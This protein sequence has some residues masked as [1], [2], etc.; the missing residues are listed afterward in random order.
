MMTNGRID[1]GSLAAAITGDV[2]VP[3]DDGYDTTR[4]VWNGMVDRRPAVI[5]RCASTHDVVAAIAFGREHGLEL[6]TRGG[7]HNVA[8]R[9]VVD[10][11]LMIDLGPMT[12]VRVDPDARRAH[13]QPGARWGDV[14]QATQAHGLATPGG[15]VSV[16]GV[17]G[18]TLG[19]GVGFLSCAYGTASDNLVAAE[20]VTADGEVVRANEDENPDLLWALRGG[21]GGFGVVTSFEFALHPVGPE[22]AVAQAYVLAD[23]ARE[24]LTFLREYSADS[25][26]EVGTYGLAI[27]IPPVDPFPAEHHGKVAIAI[28]AMHPGSVEEGERVLA[29]IGEFDQAILA[30]VAPMPYVDLQQ[31]FDAGSPDGSRYYFKSQYLAAL[32]DEA[33]DVIVDHLDPFP[34]DFTMIGLEPM[35][36]AISRVPRDATAFPHR[37]SQFVFGVWAG[38]SDPSEDDQMMAWARSVHE[39]M[40]PLGNGGMYAN[41]LDQ[42]DADV[43]NRAFRGNWDRLLDVKRTWDPDNVFAANQFVTLSG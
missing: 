28:V 36:G 1:T 23:H 24:A 31:S 15:T 43:V 4:A 37:D 33:I 14:D 25:P 42:D 11:G 3:G 16:T 18:L 32:P 29:P 2:L 22:V 39:A 5:V 27:R 40:V 10:D 13:V 9:A 21:G 38:W 19:G 34:G 35:G 12:E 20:L 6:S 17:A 30:F 7:G 8:G 41:Y 26:D